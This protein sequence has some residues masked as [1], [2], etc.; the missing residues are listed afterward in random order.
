MPT[1]RLSGPGRKAN[2]PKDHKTAPKKKHPAERVPEQSPLEKECG[3][4]E[5]SRQRHRAGQA[6]FFDCSQVEGFAYGHPDYQPSQ[7]ERPL[8]SGYLTVA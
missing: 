2:H 4:G 7:E 5:G 6:D 3:E 8:V 1:E